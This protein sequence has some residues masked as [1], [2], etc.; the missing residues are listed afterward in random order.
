M[1]EK[2][3]EVSVVLSQ[4]AADVVSHKLIEI[5]SEGTVFENLKEAPDLCRI[6]AY[7]PA[8][9]ESENIV[10]QIQH[11]LEELAKFGI[12]VGDSPEIV[13]KMMDSVDWSSNWKKYFKPTKIGKHVVVKPSWEAYDAQSD[14]II[15]E[16]DPGMAFGSGLHPSTRLGIALL[17]QYMRP[18]SEVLDVGV[19]SGILSIASACLDADYVLGVDV[20]PEAVAI[21]RENIQKNSKN[22]RREPAIHERIELRVGSIDT[23]DIARQFDC[24]VMNIRPNIILPLAPYVA[25]YLRTGGALIISGILEEE[26]PELAN[27]IHRFGFIVQNQ[28]VEDDW[29]AYVLSEI[30]NE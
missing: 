29:I 19:G 22:C 11:Y 20:D 23:L 24:I 6:K 17:E 18:G 27:Q 7:Y 10:K 9:P 15:I 13:S 3:R 25:T 21:A 14:D 12:M 5:G 30:S 26:G 2:W 1:A 16:I 4:E 28:S 8:S